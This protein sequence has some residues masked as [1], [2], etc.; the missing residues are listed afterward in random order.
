MEEGPQQLCLAGASR[1]TCLPP[2]AHL[3]IVI[4]QFGGKPFSCSPL[5][6]EQWL[7]CLFVG[8]GELVWGQVSVCLVTFPSP[9]PYPSPLQQHSAGHGVGGWCVRGGQ[10]CA[11]RLRLGL[12]HRSVSAEKRQRAM[13]AMS[14]SPSKITHHSPFHDR[15]QKSSPRM[16]WL[17]KSPYM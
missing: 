2:T 12:C 5:S 8:V 7:W 4:V 17:G 15:S 1:W 9:T 6:T 11:A 3:Q 16:R 14:Q 13:A 10:H